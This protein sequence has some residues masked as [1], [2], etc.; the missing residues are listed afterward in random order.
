M[1]DILG[2]LCEVWLL[3]DF[4]VESSRYL[5]HSIHQQHFDRSLKNRGC[6]DRYL[7][8]AQPFDGDN[9]S[10]SAHRK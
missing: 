5:R 4:G 6:T 9:H 8:L 1:I 7:D 10:K 2:V 3:E